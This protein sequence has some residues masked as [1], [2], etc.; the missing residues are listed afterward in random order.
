MFQKLAAA[1]LAFCLVTSC[2]G[3]GGGGGGSNGGGGGSSGVH[4][5]P[6]HTNVDFVYDEGAVFMPTS[7]VVVTASGTFNGTLYIGAVADGQGIDPNIQAA[8]TGTSATF[9]IQAKS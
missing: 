8:I 4:F 6:D 7:S 2:G 9:S 5:T 3:G 1:L